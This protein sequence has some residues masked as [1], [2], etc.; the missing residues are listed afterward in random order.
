MVDPAA[1]DTADRMVGRKDV[2]SIACI[3]RAKVFEQQ[4]QMGCQIPSLLQILSSYGDHY[5]TSLVHWLKI[6]LL[7]NNDTLSDSLL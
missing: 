6:P 1:E 5:R 7:E 2:E 4:L 3:D